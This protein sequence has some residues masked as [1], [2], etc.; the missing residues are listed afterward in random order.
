VTEPVR[1][2]AA[3]QVKPADAPAMPPAS[4]PVVE[5]KPAAPPIQPTQE[6]PKMQGL[7]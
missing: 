1:Q 2:S 4:A 5:A 7:E 3:V 6:M